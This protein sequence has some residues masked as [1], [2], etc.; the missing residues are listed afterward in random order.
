MFTL[1]QLEKLSELGFTPKK[2]GEP[3]LDEVIEW[4]RGDD[5]AVEI[6][7]C[8]MRDRTIIHLDKWGPTAKNNWEH[9]AVV[10]DI[11]DPRREPYP[12]ISSALVALAEKVKEN[13]NGNAHRS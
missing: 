13:T 9:I 4:V 12:D 11:N 2:Q 5:P 1:G 8:N 10:G 3:T 7:I 6:A